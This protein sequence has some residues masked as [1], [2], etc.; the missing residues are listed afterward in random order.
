[1]APGRF[2][3]VAED[4]GLIVPIGRWVLHTACQQARAW[5]IAGLPPLVVSVNVS[6]R[7]FRDGNIVETIAE[8]L[9][10]SAWRPVTCRSS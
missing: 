3:A 2:I 9:R 8:A 6:P 5:Q 1:V 10:S 4:T 7:Q